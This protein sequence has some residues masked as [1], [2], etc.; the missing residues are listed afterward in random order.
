MS[1]GTVQAV[2]QSVAG[3][4]GRQDG[5]ALA[6]ALRFDMGNTSLLGQ[7]SSGRVGLEAVCG[8]S[9]SEPYD[10]ML[11]E[12]FYFLRAAQEGDDIKAYAHCERACA[13]FQA[14]FEKDTD[15]SLPAL[16]ALC[17]SLR[18][19]AARADRALVA[20][21]EKASR[22]QEAARTMQRF[23]QVTVTDRSALPVSKKWG[24]LGVI[25]A[26]FKV[27][28]NINN[29]R[30]CQNLIR[31]VEGPAFPKA[32]DGQIVE[33]RRFPKGEIVTYKYFTGR[34]AKQ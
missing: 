7:L 26:L 32:L 27:Y 33:G 3:A 30:L 21:G 29:L 23:F 4:I 22:Q 1:L 6:A 13:C 20:K 17:L 19:A 10:E 15:W 2:A 24:A 31:A 9:L 8:G 12:H 25:N 28:F 14:V 5:P 16:H 11:L 18:L 34:R